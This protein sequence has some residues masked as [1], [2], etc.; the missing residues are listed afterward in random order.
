MSLSFDQLFEHSLVLTSREP[1]FFEKVEHEGDGKY[2]LKMLESACSNNDFIDFEHCP[3]T[4]DLLNKSNF[5]SIL[6]LGWNKVYDQDPEFKTIFDPKDGIGELEEQLLAGQWSQ[7]ARGRTKKLAQHKAAANVLLDIIKSGRHKEFLIPG[8]NAEEAFKLITTAMN[9]EQN[10]L[11]EGDNNGRG[12]TFTIKQGGGVVLQQQQII[13]WVGR[14]QELIMKKRIV[15]KWNDA[16]TSEN[17]KSNDIMHNCKLQFDILDVSAT[18]L[19]R[20]LEADSKAR[21]KKMAKQEAFRKIYEILIADYGPFNQI[22]VVNEN[23]KEKKENIVTEMTENEENLVV[24]EEGEIIEEEKVISNNNVTT[25]TSATDK[26]SLTL[27]PKDLIELS[28]IE[29]SQDCNE[30]IDIRMLLSDILIDREVNTPRSERLLRCILEWKNP[31]VERV[32]SQATLEFIETAKS[33]IHDIFQV[34]LQIST[35]HNN[36]KSM[37]C[38]FGGEGSD[39]QRARDDACWQALEYL[40][41]FGGFAPKNGNKNGE[42]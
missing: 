13:N 42:E 4:K 20:R 15:C 30:T 16:Y 41:I 37:L 32:F 36:K 24:I 35:T 29:R 34:Y 19:E 38:T 6:K 27:S 22:I 3:Y 33:Q 31:Q 39:L 28:H 14:V 2:K 21:N 7:T 8:R 10:E 18:K 9:N 17:E 12:G 26:Y 23:K 5:I 1:N 25:I 40:Y 11:M